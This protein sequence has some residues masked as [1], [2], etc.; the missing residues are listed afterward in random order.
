MHQQN[1]ATHRLVVVQRPVLNGKI[2][3]IDG[4]KG[5]ERAFGIHLN[6]DNPGAYHATIAIRLSILRL[7]KFQP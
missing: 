4:N 6:F 5:G 2:V 3:T 1:N 7:S